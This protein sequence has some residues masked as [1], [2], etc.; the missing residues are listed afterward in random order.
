[1]DTG[2][3]EKIRAADA[4]SFPRLAEFQA[5]KSEGK[6]RRPEDVAESIIRKY[7]I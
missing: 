2:M 4:K 6:L 1:M 7:I 3:Q 5:L